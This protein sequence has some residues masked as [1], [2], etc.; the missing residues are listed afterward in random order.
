[1]EQ[2][3]LRSEVAERIREDYRRRVAARRERA[4]SVEPVT[5]AA[6]SKQSPGASGGKEAPAQV[7]DIEQLRRQ[8][9]EAWRQ[10]R[11]NG[12]ET[13]EGQEPRRVLG[14]EGREREASVGTLGHDDD[15]AL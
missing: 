9:R 7:R 12:T 3:G 15:A 4:A 1:M 13:R 6:A 10:L 11:T 5:Q 8:A 14:G 2:R